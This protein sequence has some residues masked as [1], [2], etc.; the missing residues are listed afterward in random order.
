MRARAVRIGLLVLV[1]GLRAS[2]AERP[3]LVMVLSVDQMRADYLDRFR[4]WF[5]RDGFNRFL[6]RGARFPEARYRHAATLTCPGHAAIGSGLDPRDT[7]VVANNW[8]DSA[9]GRRE[10]CVEDRGARWVGQ[11]PGGPAI[12]VLPAS[13][14]LLSGNFLGD[15]LKEKFP[16]ARVVSVSLKDRG[17]VPMG[18]RKADAAVWFE[19]SWGRF[20]TSTYYPLRA[21]LLAFNEKLPAFFASHRRWGLS[22]RIPEKDLSRVTFDPPELAR[23]KETLAG[24]G[25]SFPHALPSP[26]T[27][28]ESPMGDEL[29][30]DF[31]RHAIRDFRL[32]RNPGGAPDLLFVG[33]SSLDYYGH[34]AGPDSREVA[35]GIVRLDV[36][37]ES[38]FRW[39]DAEVGADRTLFF[40]TADHGMTPIPEVAREKARRRTGRDDPGLAGRVDFGNALLVGAAVRDASPNRLALERHLA[41]TFKYSL[42]PALPNALE[43]AI[44][45]F[46]E[47]TGFY[48]NRPVIARRRISP[49]KVK[50]T[51]RNWLR[52]RPG[53]RAAYTNTEV[54]GGLPATEPLSLAI[55]RAFRADR[56]PDVLVYLAPGWIFRAEPGSTHGEPTDDD[57]RVPLLAW[58]PGVRAGSWNVRVSPLSI[59]RTVGAL[60]GFEAGA[61]DAEVLEPVLGREEKVR[62]PAVRP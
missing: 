20:V 18:G 47:P 54:A 42:D 40:L 43:G 30:L 56:S 11:P 8:I 58:G 10:Y 52:A 55:A 21:S 12:S 39:L 17:A 9:T 48:L 24:T 37:L 2:A 28:V 1:L 38:F 19:R 13:P 35:D 4:P 59:A 15:R 7:G 62:R 60:F 33:L 23:F 51:V 27:V 22:G 45:R 6:E 57:S 25:E 46:E 29:L 3:A 53:I 36:Q 26:A 14:V 31:A 5:G 44:S 34:R 32:G 49:E 41:A 61:A 16:A 50:E